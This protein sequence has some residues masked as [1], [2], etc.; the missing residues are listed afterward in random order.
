MDR[1]NEIPVKAPHENTTLQ[2]NRIL[3]FFGPSVHEI[4]LAFG[5]VDVLVK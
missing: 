5:V 3:R 2:I 4:S 1:T